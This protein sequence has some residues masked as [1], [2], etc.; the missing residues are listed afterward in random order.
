MH[1]SRTSRTCRP[2][3]L[4]IVAAVAAIASTAPAAFAAA[5][6]YA[7]PGGGGTTC[8]AADP[9]DFE[10]A[11]EG[12]KAG[13]EVIV[14]PGDYTL[15]HAVTD[16]AAIT[17]HGVAGRPRPRLH[18]SGP[19]GDG[20]WLENGSDLR[21]V[22]ID[23]PTPTARTLVVE[24][25]HVDQ[26]IARTAGTLNFPALIAHDS[27]VTN[28]IFV[29]TGDS[30]AAVGTYVNYLGTPNT[31]V[32]LRNVTAIATGSGGIGIL[33][34]A[35]GTPTNLLIRTINVIARGGPGGY[36]L[37]ADAE[38]S[39]A[40][41]TIDAARSNYPNAQGFGP[42]ASVTPAGSADNQTAAPA[43]RDAA[44]GDYRE[45]AGSPTI[46]AGADSGLNGTGDVDGDARTVGKT[47]IG[48][49]E[50][51][52][53]PV[54]GGTSPTGSTPSTPS[55]FAGVTLAS[56][57]LRF[58]GRYLR[59][60]L[61]CPAGTPGGCTGKATLTARRRV[62]GSR[63]LSTL[64]LGR[65]RVALAAGQRKTVRVRVPLGARRWLR[66]AHRRGGQ[67]T[68]VAH[69]GVGQSHTTVTRVRIIRR[70]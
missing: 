8:S 28:S 19:K 17:I 1:T 32:T 13:A 23:Q 34:G 37:V 27:T 38:G 51:V 41:V 52:A 36:G 40:T 31:T 65:A 42:N 5:P 61:S 24:L 26:V 59:A 33:G 63:A 69:N 21:Y 12:A 53:P 25:G 3:L 46:D 48:A 18:F 35:Y 56:T 15:I 60:V 47:D 66:S 16:Q 7:S 43:F 20:L 57:R 64:R 58:D 10:E 54:G 50:F 22:E 70:R 29:S 55:A 62:A 68:L 45:A 4:A 9:C 49:D 39:A 6:R 11:V 14:A 2:A 67:A 30:G 44:K